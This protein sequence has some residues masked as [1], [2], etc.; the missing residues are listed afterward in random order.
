MGFQAATEN[1]IIGEWKM[2]D[3]SWAC[4][5][6]L[7]YLFALWQEF[8]FFPPIQY[9]VLCLLLLLSALRMS[10]LVK[11]WS[12]EI[13][14]GE[15]KTELFSRENGSKQLQYKETSE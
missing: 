8:V 2:A 12:K 15:R 10:A 7:F 14:E 11:V 4:F 6:H 9:F 3:F 13:N 1:K 5:L